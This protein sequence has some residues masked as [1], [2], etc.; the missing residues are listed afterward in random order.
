[1]SLVI[2]LK[3][4]H[5]FV[6]PYLCALAMACFIYKRVHRIDLGVIRVVGCHDRCALGT[7]S[8]DNDAR[9]RGVCFG[10]VRECFCDAWKVFVGQAGRARPSF[11]LSLISNNDVGVGDDLL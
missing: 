9:A 4:K 11:G 2:S 5:L 6:W 10:L 1:M 7:V 3:T 8:E